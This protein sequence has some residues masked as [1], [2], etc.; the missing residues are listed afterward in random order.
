MRRRRV[1]LAT[2]AIV[3]GVAGCS[4]DGDE[5]GTTSET[6]RSG[7]PTTTE[8]PS[9]EKATASETSTSTSDRETPPAAFKPAW[10]FDADDDWTERHRS[11]EYPD[12]DEAV[13]WTPDYA[14]SAEYAH[15]PSREELAAAVGATDV[16]PLVCGVAS[17][18]AL[19]KE[20]SNTSV[21]LVAVVRE[22]F[23]TK[24]EPFPASVVGPEN[25]EPFQSEL[26]SGRKIGHDRHDV[27]GDTGRL[28]AP[29]RA[30]L[31]RE[32]VEVERVSYAADGLLLGL[33]G[34]EERV[35]YLVGGAW[36]A[37]DRVTLH[38]SDNGTIDVSATVSGE[39]WGVEDRLVAVLNDME[40]R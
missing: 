25:V 15:V 24:F 26:E 30:T 1:L 35:G 14:R 33:V 20:F 22:W 3:S 2:A 12:S 27:E 29:F 6:V 13:D 28:D 34:S 8:T 32:S 5:T 23:E 11:T 31:D 37:E 40:Q 39:S 36:P 38:T 21:G 18:W 19:P 16:P 17:K 9:S 10:S 4:G 7:T